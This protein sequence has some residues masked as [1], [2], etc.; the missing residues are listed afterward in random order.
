MMGDSM[1]LVKCKYQD[2][3]YKATKWLQSITNV[4]MLGASMELVKCKYQDFVL[5][6]LMV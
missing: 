4:Y 5:L 3:V 2:F 6:Y 1:E